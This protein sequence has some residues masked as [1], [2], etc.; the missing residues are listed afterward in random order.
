MTQ[1]FLIHQGNQ[2]SEYSFS[3][4]MAAEFRKED[5]KFCFWLSR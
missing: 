2:F 1:E 3:E 5:G 4:E